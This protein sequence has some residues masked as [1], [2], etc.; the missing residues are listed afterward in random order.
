M[1][2]KLTIVA[3]VAILALTR[4]VLG[5]GPAAKPDTARVPVLIERGAPAQAATPASPHLTFSAKFT[6]RHDETEQQDKPAVVKDKSGSG[7]RLPPTRGHQ[8]A[9]HR[10]RGG[11]AMAS[12]LEGRKETTSRLQ[13][14]RRRGK[15]VVARTDEAADGQG[16]AAAAVAGSVGR[17]SVSDGGNLHT[18]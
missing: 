7:I 10:S 12:K 18:G 14:L 2:I 16:C 15:Q 3:A 6:Q 8:D 1:L 13:R 11:R 9:A 17:R 5:E 4:P